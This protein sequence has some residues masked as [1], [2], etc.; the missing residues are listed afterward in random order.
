M[1]KLLGSMLDIVGTGRIGLFDASEADILK[2]IDRMLDSAAGTAV[3]GGRLAGRVLTFDEE[4]RQRGW[5]ELV[6]KRPDGRNC[7]DCL[8]LHG[9]EMSYAEFLDIK[10]TTKCDG[11]CR[12]DFRAGGEVGGEGM[13]AGEDEP[14]TEAEIQ[15]ALEA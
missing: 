12:C 8:E 14:L 4:E 1:S 5:W 11:N 6:G 9:Q 15:A 3:H 13:G 7:E 10:F 2:S